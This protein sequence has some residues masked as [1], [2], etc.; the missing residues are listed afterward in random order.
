MAVHSSSY[1]RNSLSHTEIN[2]FLKAV[3]SLQSSHSTKLYA[4]RLP[5]PSVK[6]QPRHSKVVYSR[7]TAG[8]DLKKLNFLVV[9]KTIVKN[10]SS[11]DFS[12]STGTAH[13]AA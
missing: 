7:D 2:C 10:V 4:W 1:I 6:D 9:D 12:V 13:D 8:R 5:H 11:V 3:W